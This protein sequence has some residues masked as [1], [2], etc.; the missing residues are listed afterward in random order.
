MNCCCGRLAVGLANAHSHGC[1]WATCCKMPVASV[2][3][4]R[5]HG[6]AEGLLL[7]QAPRVEKMQTACLEPCG[8][9]QLDCRCLT[10][11]WTACTA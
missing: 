10:G 3:L 7:V 4:A 8:P 6:N 2:V 1:V 9:V 5:H 11:G